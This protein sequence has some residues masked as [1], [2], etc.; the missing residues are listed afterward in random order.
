MTWPCCTCLTGTA[1]VA[2]GL[3]L[4]WC[5]GFGAAVEAVLVLGVVVSAA[6]VVE[7][8][9]ERDELRSEIADQRSRPRGM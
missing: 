8:Q 6:G 3:A 1:V 7:V 5:A 4:E 9:W 2:G